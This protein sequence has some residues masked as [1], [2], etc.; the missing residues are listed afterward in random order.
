MAVVPSINKYWK[1]A[2]WFVSFETLFWGGGIYTFETIGHILQI[3]DFNWPTVGLHA[4]MLFVAVYCFK[5][6]V[7]SWVEVMKYGMDDI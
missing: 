1:T 2:I 3:V 6:F 5:N 4:I 7:K